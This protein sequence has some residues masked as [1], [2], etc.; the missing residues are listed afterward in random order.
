MPARDRGPARVVCP[1]NSRRAALPQ[2]ALPCRRMLAASRWRAAGC[3]CAGRARP[4]Q[5]RERPA[6]PGPGGAL[7]G[8]IGRRRPGRSSVSSGCET[9]RGERPATEARGEPPAPRVEAQ[10]PWRA[11]A[12]ELGQMDVRKDARKVAGNRRFHPSRRR[13]PAN[14]SSGVVSRA[15]CPARTMPPGPSLHPRCPVISQLPPRFLRPEIR[16][17]RNMSDA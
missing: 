11:A 14:G 17:S 5:A 8:R 2:R 3:P 4:A 7:G 10:E 16:P 6:G 13:R 1:G 9:A 12:G 15:R